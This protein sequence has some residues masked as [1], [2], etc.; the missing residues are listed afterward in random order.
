MNAFF[1]DPVIGKAQPRLLQAVNRTW[2]HSLGLP[3]GA[4]FTHWASGPQ[5]KALF[6]PILQT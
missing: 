1:V 4:I 5:V 6:K 3:E 2:R